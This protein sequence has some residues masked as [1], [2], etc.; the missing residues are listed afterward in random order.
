MYHVEEEYERYV[1][2]YGGRLVSADNPSQEIKLRRKALG[3]TQEELGNLLDLRRE[4]I[5]RI[6]NGSIKPTFDFVIRFSRTLA[7]AKVIRE[8]KALSEVKDRE[9]S[10][11][12]INPNLLM[13]Y[14]NMPRRDLEMISEIG[15]KGY[16]KS[17]AK[18]LKNL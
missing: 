6:E 15:I 14:F 16:E 17:R 13:R 10:F 7:A 5:S 12:G 1:R 18:I 3:I 9:V 4:T 11:P 8:L 2:Y